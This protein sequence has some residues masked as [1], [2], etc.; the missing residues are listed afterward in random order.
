M[1]IRFWFAF[2]VAMIA[3]PVTADDDIVR[4]LATIKQVS[5]EGKGNDDA[6]PAWKTLVTKGTAALFPTLEAVD[7]GNPTAGNWLRTAAEAIADAET[8]AGRKLPAD[9]LE[10]FVTNT[11]FAPSARRTT[12]ELL[13]AQDPS[14]KDRLLPKFV[15]DKSLELRRDAIAHQLDILEKVARPSI[16]AD[17]E[18]LFL[19]TRDKDQVEL[20][21]KKLRE[22]GGSPSITE[23]LGFVTFTSLVGPFDAPESKGF[24]I[25]F[26]PDVA[27]DNIGTFKGKDGL[28]LKWKPFSTVD[29]NGKFDLNN[30]LGKH[31]NSVAYALAY[32]IAP[33]EMPCEV[34][35]T[36]PTAVKIFLN[37][38]E[39][40]G[41]DEYHHGDRFDAHTGIGMLKAGENVLVLK[42][43]QNNQQESWAQRWQFQM[44]VCD[45]TGGP[46]PLMQKVTKGDKVEV[47]KLGY[48]PTAEAKKE[49]KK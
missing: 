6:G 35:V 44:R 20:V 37:Q 24:S 16:K 31:K 5:R 22:N 47:V 11:K 28:E 9:K 21:A 40:F 19:A 38:K 36:S 3:S 14:A 12:Y 29:L 34:R 10:A 46:L 2:A 39:L 45:D 18:S 15:N 32:I 48:I 30:T 43:C 49:E 7:D 4:A 23:H 25:A 33:K 13:L 26:P 17:L 27:D 41:R 1:C 8:T 42:V